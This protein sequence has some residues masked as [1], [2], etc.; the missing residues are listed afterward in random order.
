MN[1]LG[2]AM[3]DFVGK[4]EYELSFKKDDLIMILGQFEDQE[5]WWQGLTIDSKKGWFPKDYIITFHQFHLQ[6]K[7]QEKFD[8]I[9]SKK[10]LEKEK[11]TK[12]F[13]EQL[14]NI[15]R[16]QPDLPNNTRNKVPNVVTDCVK[17]IREYCMGTDDLFIYALPDKDIKHLRELYDYQVLESVSEEFPKTNLYVIPNLLLDFLR[18]LPSP[19]LTTNCTP[20]FLNKLTSTESLESKLFSI[21]SLIQLLPRENKNLLKILIELLYDLTPK[22]QN[23][24]KENE[25]DK[26]I[27]KN[28]NKNKNKNQNNNNNNNNIDNRMNKKFFIS[29]PLSQIFGP[30]L[31]DTNI[32]LKTNNGKRNIFDESFALCTLLINEYSYFFEGG[33]SLDSLKGNESSIKMVVK[34]KISYN[35]D[36][37]S[38]LSF[39]K[40]QVFFVLKKD[41][42]GWWQGK[43]GEQIGLFESWMVKEIQGNGKG[44]VKK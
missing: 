35:G 10:N 14:E 26:I 16:I 8:K 34:A 19:L 32:N 40:D 39:K 42:D 5:G 2:I 9:I 12:I 38:E 11:K 24:Y 43:I 28:K 36:D 29:N 21:K 30:I 41:D 37:E 44:N 20:Q 13:G 4:S 31:I 15:L 25:V 3:Q 1:R 18:K 23:T 7:K 6:K 22:K 33:E 17:H 27:N